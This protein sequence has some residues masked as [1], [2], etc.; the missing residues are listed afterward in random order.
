MRFSLFATLGF[1]AFSHAG[2]YNQIKDHWSF[3]VSAGEN[4]DW[5]DPLRDDTL[6]SD[7]VIPGTHNSM[8]Y[9]LESSLW[10]SQ[11][12][13]LERQLAGGIRYIDITCR[14]DKNGILVYH[15][16]SDTTYS[17]P[18]V[19]ET[20]FDFLGEHARETV[21]LRIQ[22]GGIFDDSKIF[23]QYFDQYFVPGSDLGNRAVERVYSKKSSIPT[24]PTLG[25]LRGKLYILQ[26]FETRPAGHYGLPWN[27]NTVSNYN[28]K[29]A[30]GTKFLGSKW[31]EVKSHLSEAPE[32]NKLR[33][34][35]TTAS[36]GVSPINVAAR[37]H[38]KDGMNKYLGR[39]LTTKEGNCFGIVVMDFPGQHLVARILALN[40]KYRAPKPESRPSILDET[41][42]FED[43]A[44]VKANGA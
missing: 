16:L 44:S 37:N 36:F 13:P 30:A 17:L 11:N 28:S 38:P 24:V 9:D 4:A 26:D 20:I 39:Y 8:T 18:I 14:H 35:H 27:S 7:L 41:I 25:E 23:F 6:L 2:E 19:L 12:I 42:I 1:L 31:K 40:E 3:D 29:I 21:I 10:Q 15:G 34:T 43:P 33:I 32:P 5:M 22:R